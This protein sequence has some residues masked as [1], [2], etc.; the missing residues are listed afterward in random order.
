M[1][2]M[3]PGASIEEVTQELI[4]QAAKLWG[5]ERAE[6]MGETLEQTARNLLSVANNLPDK[7]IEP[8]FYQYP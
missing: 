3:K 1:V 6:A 8:S 4:Q 5:L 2:S 7:D